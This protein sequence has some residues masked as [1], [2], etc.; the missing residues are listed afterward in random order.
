VRTCVIDDA[1]LSGVVTAV[2]NLQRAV[3]VSVDGLLGPITA[4]AAANLS[5]QLLLERLVHQRC[6]RYFEIIKADNTQ[7]TFGPGWCDRAFLFLA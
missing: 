5:S 2:K 4:R 1:V 7:A 6:R 3:D